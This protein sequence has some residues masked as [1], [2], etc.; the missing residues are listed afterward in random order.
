MHDSEDLREEARD[1]RPKAKP[2]YIFLIPVLLGLIAFIGYQTVR[3]GSDARTDQSPY[4]IDTS[5]AQA[6][7]DH[8]VI[9]VHPHARRPATVAVVAPKK[10]DASPSPAPSPSTEPS[11]APPT[12][13]P[14]PSHAAKTQEVAHLAAPTRPHDT[15]SAEQAIATQPVPHVTHAADTHNAAIITTTINATAPP[16]QQAAASD[17]STT[18]PITDAPVV[19]HHAPPAT[20]KPVQIAAAPPP[21]PATINASDRVVEARMIYAATPDYPDIARDQGARGTS[22]VFVTVD[23]AGS[24]VHMSIASSS[25]N[26][27][28][29]RAALSAARSSRYVAPKVD[30]KPAT[31][32][33]RVTYDFSP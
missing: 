5:V 32:T 28:L 23:P 9:T 11:T 33:Y 3:M 30:G 29:D 31:E 10:P 16:Q 19:V 18:P 20:A 4:A 12:P 15:V 8:G 25:G 2:P 26:P 14:Q 17:S 24:I 27:S 13:K 7:V 21:T 1:E 22:V 6:V